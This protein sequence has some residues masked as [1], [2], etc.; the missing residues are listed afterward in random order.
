[1]HEAKNKLAY[2]KLPHTKL[3]SPFITFTHTC[4]TFYHNFA[5]F[6]SAI[7]K[8]FITDEIKIIFV[9]VHF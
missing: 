6:T 8:T 1:M 4:I 2:Y 7:T 5:L 9:T 3:L